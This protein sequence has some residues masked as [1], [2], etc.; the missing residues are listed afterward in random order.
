[1]PQLALEKPHPEPPKWREQ[2]GL[3]ERMRKGIVAPVDDMWVPSRV[4]EFRAELTWAGAAS[5]PE[6]RLM[7]IPR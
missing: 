4:L 7:L 6:L 2:Y 3:I 5:D 1:M